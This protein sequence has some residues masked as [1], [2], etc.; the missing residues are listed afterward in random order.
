MHRPRRLIYLSSGLHRGDEVPLDDLD[1]TRRRWDGAR[2]Y[3]ETKL[4]VVAL[5][6]RLARDWP[7]VASS[8]VDPGWVRTR[9]GGPS[10]PLDLQTGQQT[11]SWLAVSDDAA[12]LESGRYWH[13]LRQESPAIQASDLVFQNELIAT[14]AELTGVALP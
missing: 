7:Q 4:C 10:A 13:H 1:W 6:F 2:A 5:A 3:A 14:L 8:A 9:M 12:A 11:Q